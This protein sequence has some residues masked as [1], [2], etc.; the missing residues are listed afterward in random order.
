MKNNV[1]VK[2]VAGARRERVEEGK[3]GALIVRV[4]E[5]ARRGEAN[6]RV[7][8]LLALHFGVP[9]RTVRIVS[10]ARSP[11]KRFAIG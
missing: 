10:G 1:R 5:E 9:V 11:G 3:G 4:R 2:V 7:R 6:E 8:Q